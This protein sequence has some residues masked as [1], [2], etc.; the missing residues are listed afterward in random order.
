[1]AY[2]EQSTSANAS[3]CWNWFK[4]L[5]QERDQGEPSLIAGITCQI[6]N[7]FKVESARV[8]VAGLSAGGAAATRRSRR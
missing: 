7:D 1:V 6:M 2:P 3:K 8:S 5:D 4:A